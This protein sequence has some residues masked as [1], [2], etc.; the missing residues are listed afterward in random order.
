MVEGR[1]AANV[2]ITPSNQLPTIPGSIVECRKE[3][4]L[5]R[6]GTCHSTGAKRLAI[7]IIVIKTENTS[8][9][10]TIGGRNI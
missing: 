6:M 10:I 5:Q 9:G 4:L 7:I 8:A 1:I 2:T 3:L